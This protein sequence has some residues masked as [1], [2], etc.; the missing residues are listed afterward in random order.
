MK[1]EMG[2]RISRPA[3]PEE[4]VRHEQIRSEIAAET[5][6]LQQW[7]RAAAVGHKERISVGTVFT[8]EE[9]QVVKAIDEYALS[10]SLHGRGDVVRHAL[11]NLLGIEV[12]VSH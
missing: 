4:K 10:H 6:D 11:A 1:H 12:P 3:S 2:K 8:A 5:A 9:S 7:A